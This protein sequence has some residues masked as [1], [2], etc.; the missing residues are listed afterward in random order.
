MSENNIN[1][2]TAGIYELSQ[3]PEIG[4]EKALTILDY[5]REKGEFRSWDELRDIPGFTD[6]MIE[7]LKRREIELD[8]RVRLSIKGL[9]PESGRGKFTWGSKGGISG[10]DMED[11]WE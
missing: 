9:C 5:R 3:I 1:L 10:D 11:V 6:E 2:N 7:R 4:M 8:G